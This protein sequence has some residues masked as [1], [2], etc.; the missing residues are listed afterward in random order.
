MLFHPLNKISTKLGANTFTRIQ[1][2]IKKL[3]VSKLG[4]IWRLYDS[5]E[6]EGGIQEEN[7][8]KC[9]NIN[10]LVFKIKCILY[11][12]DYFTKEFQ[13]FKFMVEMINY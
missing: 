5:I 10:F 6:R 11:I 1:G 9:T 7:Y 4:L 3:T 2:L 8:K 12:I 13:T